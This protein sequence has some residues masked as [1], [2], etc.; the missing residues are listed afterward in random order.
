MKTSEVAVVTMA[1]GETFI[2]KFVQYYGNCFGQDNVFVISHGKSEFHRR[3]CA[4]VNHITIPRA[5]TSNFEQE[6]IDLIN[7]FCNGLLSAYEIVIFV[8]VDE[9]I[10]MNPNKKIALRDYLL[11]KEFGF[12]AP[13]GLNVVTDG[14][15]AKAC[16]ETPLL[17]QAGFLVREEG[18]CKPAIR[19]I[20]G[21]ATI[22]GHALH[23]STFEVDQNLLL[24]HL[25]YFDPGSLERYTRLSDDIAKVKGVPFGFGQWANGHRMFW[26][27]FASSI[28]IPLQD[29]NAFQEDTKELFVFRQEK[30]GVRYRVITK[31]TVP[32]RRY[33]IPPDLSNVL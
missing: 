4:D 2:E 8:D 21:R 30:G 1:F 14:N 32:K 25:K 29:W 5:L 16:W 31:K 19:Q 23:E 27:Y 17:A 24:L 33:E 10:V 15:S 6:R 9:F 3:V 13:V 18:F 26:D 11:G 22:G 28:E 7:N 20:R 12:L